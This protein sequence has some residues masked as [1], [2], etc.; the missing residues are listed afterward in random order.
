MS[1]V[2]GVFDNQSQAEKAVNKIREAGITEDK[3]SIVAKRDNIE[4]ADEQQNQGNDATL[5][6]QN[7][8]GGTTTGGVLGGLAGIL[9]GAGALAI[10]GVGPILAAGPIAAGLTGAV[11]GGIAGGLIDMGIPE[12]RGQHYEQQVKQ[13]KIL[14]TVEAEQ[15]KIEDVT[16]FMRKNGASDVESH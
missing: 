12:E 13:G 14:A 5:T 9:G 1:T 11:A 7:L 3:I 16:N 2:I 15:N 6:D 4:G 8:S 10:P